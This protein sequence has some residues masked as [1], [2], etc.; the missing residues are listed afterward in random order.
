MVGPDASDGSQSFGRGEPGCLERGV[1]V[2]RSADRKCGAGGEQQRGDGH[3]G[4]PVPDRSEHGDRESAEDGAAGSSGEREEGR[5]GEELD[6]DMG[7]PGAE[8][9]PQP[10]LARGAR[11]RR[12]P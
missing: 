4:V 8:G 5:L 12:S 6:A 3:Q 10:D 7:P 9:P 2:G 1:D 11:A